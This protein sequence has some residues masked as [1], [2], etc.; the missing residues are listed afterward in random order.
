MKPRRFASDVTLSINDSGIDPGED[1]RARIDVHDLVQQRDRLALGS[2]E[3][4]AADNRAEAAALSD[5]ADLGQHI[6]GA[7]GLATREDHYAAAVEGRL[8][9]V[10]H[11]LRQRRYRNVRRLKGFARL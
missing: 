1:L 5:A 11:A 10:P 7:L 4:V 2:L 6:V 9:H 8:H 3:R